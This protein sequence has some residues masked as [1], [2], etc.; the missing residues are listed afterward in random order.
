MID[1]SIF[2]ES[3]MQRAFLAGILVACLGALL[4]VFL[5]LRQMSLLGDGLGHVSFGGVALGLVFGIYPLGA[6]LIFSVV[7]ALAI[8]FLRERQ[9]VKGDT[10]IGILF[11]MGLALGI[12]I[13]SAH[14]AF[15]VN[16]EGYLFGSSILTISPQD[17]HVVVGVGTAL[18]VLLYA[19]YKEF[20]SMTFS[21]EAA[22]VT[23]LPVR[24]LNVVFVSL[25]AATIV[26]ATR[27]VGVLLVSS[28]L[29]VPAAAALQ[30]ARSFRVA[31]LLSMLFG[32]T[33]V[34]V[35]LFLSVVEDWAPGGSVALVAG[36]IFI[37][38]VAAKRL[39]VRATND[40]HHP[41]AKRAQPR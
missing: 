35:G 29:I 27:V 18:V 4:G 2:Q 30:L 8:H 31:I 25:A 40:A 21:E 7:G 39:L 12:V 38:A 34:L 20:F 14:K 33:S 15:N 5:V 32:T 1:W 26:V 6:A 16:I 17:L 3:W 11:T 19:F 13:L 9:I 10:A 41:N 23:G 22:K 36:S 24:L 37:V 28:L